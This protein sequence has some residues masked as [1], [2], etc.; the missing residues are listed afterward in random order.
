MQLSETCLQETK[1]QIYVTPVM[2]MG[3]FTLFEKLLS[4][5]N[6][7]IERERSKYEQGVRKLDE[8][9]IMIETMEEQL[10]RLTP[11]LVEKSKQV[12]KTV[13]RLEKESKEVFEVKEKVDEETAEAEKE[14]AVADGIKEECQQKLN[15][16]QPFFDKAIKALRTL[17]NNDFVL[18]KS[19]TNP[20]MGVRLALEGCCIMLNIPPTMKKVDGKKVPDYWE[21][22]KKLIN[23][24]KKMLDQL[25]GYDKENIDPAIIAK[26]QP[27]L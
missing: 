27:Y 8:A 20:P 16:A 13:K 22:S 11:I 17:S 18:M 3:V 19:F 14:K 4:R 2:F 10:T 7:E 6:E 15:L 26:I 1:R 5:K 12:E 21:K 9:K 24:Y 23:N 25:E